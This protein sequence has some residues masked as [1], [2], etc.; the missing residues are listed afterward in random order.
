MLG[1]TYLLPLRR[2]AP[3]T[4]EFIDYLCSLVG[5]C[6]VIVVDSSSSATFDAN[7]LAFGDLVT[8][9]KPDERFR[10]ANGK[11][12]NVLTGLDYVLTEL[13][14]IADDDVRYTAEKLE[15]ACDLA[16]GA[17]VVVPQNV[18]VAAPGAKL[19]WH[20]VWDTARTLLNRVTGGD[21]PG[22]LVVRTEIFRR[23][24]G[25][26]GNVL[27]ENLEL[28]RTVVAAGGVVRW[29]NDF[30]VAR[31]PPTTAH[32]GRQRV[33][34]AYDEFARPLRL[35]VQMAIIPMV[36]VAR[37]HPLVLLTL[38]IGVS[39]AAEVGRRRFGGRERFPVRASMWASLWVL[40]RG[41][42]AWIAVIAWVRGGVRY[43]GGRISVAAHSVEE[44]RRQLKHSHPA[45]IGSLLP[46]QWGTRTSA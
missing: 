11:V 32:F 45:E 9:L 21:F 2:T 30:Y 41:C 24:H 12:M 7:A 27:F 5:V 28:I 25:Y 33:R 34:Q 36:W 4:P 31:R 3:P 37:R 44:I 38:A 19:P 26:N 43:S 16:K 10:C 18:F 29:E 39:G 42:C 13:V 35:A 20:A 17:D 23:T 15:M 6:E 1:I 14:V 8:H 22:T 40:E 46:A